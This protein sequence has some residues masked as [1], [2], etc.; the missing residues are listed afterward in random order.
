MP[1]TGPARLSRSEVRRF[2]WDH[3]DL[4]GALF[5]EEFLDTQPFTVS[6]PPVVRRRT[7]LFSF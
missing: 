3:T 7:V 4:S 5:A 1:A 2:D 6:P